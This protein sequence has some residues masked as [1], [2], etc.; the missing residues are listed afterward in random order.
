MA[1][2]LFGQE[3]HGIYNFYLVNIAY[4]DANFR[5]RIFNNH[6]R[7]FASPVLWSRTKLLLL[8]YSL[9][10]HDIPPHSFTP[11]VHSPPSANSATTTIAFSSMSDQD[12]NNTVRWPPLFPSCFPRACATRSKPSKPAQAAQP[13]ISRHTSPFSWL[14]PK[15]KF[16]SV[17]VGSSGGKVED[18]ACCGACRE[19]GL[20]ISKS[21]LY[22][23]P[24]QRYDSR[25]ASVGTIFTNALLQLCNASLIG[26]WAKITKATCIAI[27]C[28][29]QTST[30]GTL[31]ALWA[32]AWDPVM[33]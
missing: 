10:E 3:W 27:S 26:H 20:G 14:P 25:N 18:E 1:S 23:R 21:T 28:R 12:M 13:T 22:S 4:R 5:W 11:F 24:T 6:S 30:A 19:T 2:G 16:M 9:P 32:D 17:T 33:E 8:T 7:F 31:S 15:S 29:S